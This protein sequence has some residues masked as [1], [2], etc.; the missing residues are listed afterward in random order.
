MS[1]AIRQVDDTASGSHASADDRIRAA[2]RAVYAF[3]GADPREQT[4]TVDVGSGEADVRVTSF[5]PDTTELPPVLLLH[6]IGS[7][8]AMAAPLLSYLADRRVMAVDWPGHG[9]SGRC[10]LPPG[11]SIRHHAVTTITSVL[12]Q[13][14]LE[15]VDVIGHSMGAQFALYAALDLPQRV[16]RLVLLGAPGAA[17]P[18][19]KPLAVM[20]V[21][22]QPVLGR[23]LLSVPMS[24]A[25]F[26]RS[27]EMGLGKGAL[28]DMP[29]EL[30]AAGRQIGRRA[31]SAVS[32]ASF[33]RAMI[34]GRAIRSGVAISTAELATLTQPVL[35]VWGDDDVFLSPTAAAPSIACIRD[36]ELMTL[37]ATG[38][39]PWL[40]EH[41]A[42]GAAVQRHLS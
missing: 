36:R 42:V 5:G 30:L 11:T 29:A 39:A 15:Q 17:L 34:R 31:G 6:G 33:F 32:L 9:L 1:P 20:V 40:R 28:E 26:L 13:M 10:V 21:M 16:R 14:G 25:A 22:G 24:E 2:E 23:L 35:L 4:L 41:A 8:T 27:T 18:G 37:P 3:F 12:D 7:M 19:V 38:H